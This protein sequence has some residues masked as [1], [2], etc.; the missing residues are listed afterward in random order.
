MEGASS[1]TDLN[2]L[3]NTQYS[4]ND[5][6]TLSRNYTF[7]GTDDDSGFIDGIGINRGVTI[8]GQN[9]VLD[10]ANFSRILLI[11]HANV[12]L[13]NMVFV[14]GFADDGGAIHLKNSTLL[15][16]NCTFIHNR[17]NAGGGA[18][19]A[20]LSNASIAESSFSY[21]CGEGLYV[22][23]GAVHLY[24]STA[25][26]S[27]SIFLN[28]TADAGGAVFALRSS[29]NINGSEFS[30]NTANFYGGGVFSEFFL[31]INSTVFHDN[32]AGLKGGAIHGSY[33]TEDNCIVNVNNSMLFNN[34]AQ[35]GGAVSSSNGGRNLIQNSRLYSN[36]ATYGA[37]IARFSEN[38]IDIVNCDCSDNEAVNGTVVYAPSC[39][40]VALKNS[41]FT[42]NSGKY[43]SLIYTIQ[44]AG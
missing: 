32:K 1:F 6:I 8:D 29:L 17:A 26:F 33:L 16:S 39:G 21:N 30:Y 31:K 5:T 41:N 25:N 44:G 37:V 38:S 43:G 7:N 10:G 12:T 27:N 3:I 2:Y 40:N 36:T 18:L 35:Y 15:I 11:S 9:H 14:N 24:N 20:S 34:H 22:S 19:Y 23:G 13:K 42:N 4:S 28:N